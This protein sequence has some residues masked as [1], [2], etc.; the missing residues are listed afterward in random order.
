MEAPTDYTRSLPRNYREND[1]H[2]YGKRFGAGGIDC[3]AP[4]GIVVNVI[5]NTSISTYSGAHLYDYIMFSQ[6]T[7]I[8]LLYSSTWRYL[9]TTHH[10]PVAVR[11]HPLHLSHDCVHVFPGRQRKRAA[12]PLERGTA[13]G[14]R[15]AK[16]HPV[17]IHAVAPESLRHT[18]QL[19]G[20]CGGDC[21]VFVSSRLRWTS[22]TGRR[23]SC[24]DRCPCPCLCRSRVGGGVCSSFHTQ[25]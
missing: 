2:T 22:R 4:P 16:H 14:E 20:G 3:C 11:G 8:I 1:T 19:V 25:H 5:Q 6:K 9:T 24:G 10:Q 17:P 15:P 7:C 21:H 13:V 12:K 23:G 18:K